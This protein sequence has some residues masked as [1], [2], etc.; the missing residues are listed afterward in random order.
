MKSKCPIFITL[1]SLLLNF[2]CKESTTVNPDSERVVKSGSGIKMDG[3]LPS[4]ESIPALFDEM[5]FQ[6]ATQCYLW[7]LPIVTFAEWQN[8]HYNQFK[9]SSNDLVFYNTYNDR[10][11]ILTANATT[12]YIMSFIDLAKNGPTV[13][14]MPA[15]HTAGGLGDFWQREQAV[16]GEMGPDKGKGGKYLLVPPTMKDLKPVG[17]FIVPCNTMNMFFGIRSLDPDPKSTED[18]VK[19]VKIYP[20]SQRANPTQTKIVSPPAGKKWLGNQPTGI[21]YWERLHAIL[22]VEPVEDRD[23]FFMAWLKNLGIEKGKP[24]APDEHQKQTLIAAAAKGQQMAMANSFS[25]RFADVKHWPDKKWDYVMIIKNPSQREANYD[26]FFERASYFYEATGYSKAMITKTPNLGQAYLGSYYDSEGNW[27]DGAKN[28]T[29]NVP[30]NP[31]A[32]NFWSITVYDSA[33]RC[34]IDNPQQNADLSSRKDLIKNSDGSVD[35]YFGPKAPAGKEKNWV[36]TLPG[37]HWFT[38]MRFYGPTT[39]YFDKSWKMDDI[40]EVK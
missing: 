35:L 38:Y 13:L 31:P 9:A 1:I 21:A 16:I 19:K 15:G 5:D 33:T 37:K 2:G 10:L 11:G 32:V 3:E 30:A 20:Y 26:E 23:R 14:E 8:V 36:Q 22:Q 17:Y 4:K 6:Q 25:K 18:I 7:A 29:L 28:Y 12:P 40:K 34:L 27:L 24:F 39:A